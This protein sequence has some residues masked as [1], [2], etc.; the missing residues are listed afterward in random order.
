MESCVAS[1]NLVA[2]FQG[3]IDFRSGYHAQLP[4]NG[5]TDIQQW[6][7]HGTGK[8]LASE[9]GTLPST[10]TLCLCLGQKTGAWPSFTT[11]TVNRT[12]FEL[13]E[14]KDTVFL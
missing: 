4:R 3:N 5:L 10:D 1:G 13:K 2:A 11:S 7:T 6:K 14:W 8:E 9:S 12:Y